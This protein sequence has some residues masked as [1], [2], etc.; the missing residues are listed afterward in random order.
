M[1]SDDDPATTKMEEPL[2]TEDQHEAGGPKEGASF[3][4]S[5][6]MLMCVLCVF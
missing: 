1:R 2:I 4:V 6:F 3:T 5:V